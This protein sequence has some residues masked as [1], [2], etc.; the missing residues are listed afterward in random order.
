MIELAVG[1]VALLAGGVAGWKV[2]PRI[3]K[4]LNY[5]KRGKKAAA[6]RKAKTPPPEN[7]PTEV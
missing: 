3:D 7:Q 6:T 4:K 5:K 1:L 2:G